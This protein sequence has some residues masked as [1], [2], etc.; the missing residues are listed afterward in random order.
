MAYDENLAQRLRE[1]F[2]GEAGVTERKM[3]SGLAFMVN[4]NMCCGIVGDKLMVRVGAEQYDETVRLPYAH[5]MDFTG[6]PMKGM[7]Y[8]EPRGVDSEGKLREWVDRG[9]KFVTT[10]PPK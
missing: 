3:F 8:V 9:M 6:R 1:V 4:G 5:P 10:L 2:E 7:L